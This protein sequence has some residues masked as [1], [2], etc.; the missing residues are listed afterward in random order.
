MPISTGPGVTHAGAFTEIKDRV[1]SVAPAG[2]AGDGKNGP[3]MS[4]GRE[5]EGEE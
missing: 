3:P 2:L 1:S 4:N 5:S